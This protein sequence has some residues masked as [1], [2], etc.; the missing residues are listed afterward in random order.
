MIYDCTTN[1]EGED[2]Y[3]FQVEADSATEAKNEAKQKA[4]SFF[5]S[6]DPNDISVHVKELPKGE[7]SESQV[8]H[9]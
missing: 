9:G 6:A 8:L 1:Y 5:D 3:S 2:T 4:L 7:Q